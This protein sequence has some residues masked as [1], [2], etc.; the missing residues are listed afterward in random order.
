MFWLGVQDLSWFFQTKVWTP[1]KIYENISLA[2]SVYW[3]VIRCTQLEKLIG[4][5]G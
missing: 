1:A 3:P 5:K 4:G 2:L